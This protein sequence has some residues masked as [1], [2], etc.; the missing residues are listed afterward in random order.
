MAEHVVALRNPVASR[1]KTLNW[2]LTEL[3]RGVEH[4]ADF[5]LLDTVPDAAENRA[6]LYETVKPDS[7]LV[8]ASGDGTLSQVADNIANRHAGKPEHLATTPVAAFGT[9]NKND[10]A[11]MLGGRQSTN[12]LHVVT[13]GNKI[14]VPMLEVVR[15]QDGEITEEQLALYSLGF[16]AIGLGARMANEPEFRAAQRERSPLGRK[17]ADYKLAYDAYRQS[18]VQPFRVDGEAHPGLSVFFSNGDRMAGQWRLPAS[19][20]ESEFYMGFV[21]S[22]K[23]LPAL[24]DSVGLLTNTLPDGEIRRTP[25]RLDITQ[26]TIGEIDGED[27]DMAPGTVTVSSGPS[28]TFLSTRFAAAEA[29][30]HEVEG[31]V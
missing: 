31:A 29:L 16:G 11:V 1:A 14:A 20:P 12:P 24:R 5:T 2:R 4:F 25:V 17:V 6:R 8:V 23:L 19:L 28:V 18:D 30:V 9:G 3:E 15:S 7:I 22:S 27:F 10:V 21:R 13:Q 26:P